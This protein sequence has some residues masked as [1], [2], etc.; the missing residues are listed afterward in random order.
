MKNELVNT[1]SNGTEHFTREE[2]LEMNH[3]L[4]RNIL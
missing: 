1:L 3:S 4:N 2:G